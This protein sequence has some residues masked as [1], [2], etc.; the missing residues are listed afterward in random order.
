VL[1]MFST[2]ARWALGF[3]LTVYDSGFRSRVSGLALAGGDVFS[4]MCSL[5]INVFSLDRKCS[6][7]PIVC[8]PISG[9]FLQIECVLYR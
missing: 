7:Q 4:K 9:C 6:L 3:R 1:V 5:C 8:A 2:D